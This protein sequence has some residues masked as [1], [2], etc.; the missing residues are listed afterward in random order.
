MCT[1]LLSLQ[2]L[3]WLTEE[4]DRLLGKLCGLN[5]RKVGSHDQGR[6]VLRH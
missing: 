6:E 4:A 1:L 5:R 2:R 3:L